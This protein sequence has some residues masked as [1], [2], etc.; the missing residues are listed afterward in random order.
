MF[1]R[2][3]CFGCQ[4]SIQRVSLKKV[5]FV[6]LLTFFS[7]YENKEEMSHKPLQINQR[8][9]HRYKLEVQH[10]V[11]TP[12]C[13]FRSTNKTLLCRRQSRVRGSWSSAAQGMG[14][15]GGDRNCVCVCLEGAWQ[16][17][18]CARFQDR[19]DTAFLNL[20]NSSCSSWFG[21]LLASCIS[22][23]LL[24]HL[25]VLGNARHWFCSN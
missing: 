12:P 21:S 15:V 24:N 3:A 5:K 11:G 23:E 9:L 25:D 7:S 8:E 18:G 6:G 20:G 22:R 14:A 10:S 16:H 4:R 17:I 13:H 2:C 19:S 1:K